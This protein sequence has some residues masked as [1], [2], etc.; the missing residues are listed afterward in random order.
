[1]RILLVIDYKFWAIATLANAI[2]RYLKHHKIEIICIPPKELR[3]DTANW[4]F[5]FKEKL[6]TFN[7]DIVHFH[8]WDLA[9]R[10]G[11]FVKCKKILTHHNQKDLHA[12]DWSGFALTC[13][14][15]KAKEILQQKYWN[16]SIVRHGIEGFKY[17]EGYK[18]NNTLGY[19]GRAVAWK[20]LK[21]IA[22]VARDLGL[23]VVCMGRIDDGAY[24]N[25]IDKSSLDIKFN[26]DPEKQMAI[27]QEMGAFIQNSRDGREEGTMPLL[28]AMTIGLPII[29]TRAGVA[30]DILKDEENAILVDFEDNESLKKGIKRF[31][32]MPEKKVNEMRFN[33]WNT[34]KSMTSEFM[35]LNYEKVY[36]K[37]LYEKDLVSVIIPTYNRKETV[38]E[39]IQAY[40]EQT[41]SPIEI[42]VVDDNSSDDTEFAI[43]DLKTKNPLKYINTNYNGYGLSKARNMGTLEARGHYIIYSDDRYLP[44]RDA[45]DV[46]VQAIKGTK[47]PIA[48]WGDKGAGHRDFIENFFIIRKEHIAN[49]GMFP[50]WITQYGG[51]SQEIRERLRKLNYKLK[52][53]DRATC[54]A[55]MRSKNRNKKDEVIKSKLLLWKQRN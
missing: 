50:E 54:V 36:Y 15:N 27:Y 26:A 52:Y 25:E 16:V 12:Y 29:S 19:C 55:I 51:I 38:T 35:A 31:L 45:V 32:E 53:E 3:V 24:W 34:A 23:K 42:V 37:T 20:G 41:Y 5:V 1:M 40:D 33:A 39:V 21:G 22:E 11:K 18:K 17:F 49:A 8:Y 7:P 28:E 14:T 10:L 47:E 6:R 44:N 30:K 4:E 2:Q 13:H 46:F 48:V 43:K 9:G